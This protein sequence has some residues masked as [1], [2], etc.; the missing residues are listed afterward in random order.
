MAA[1]K[2]TGLGK[3][4][5]AYFG[6]KTANEPAEDKPSAVKAEKGSTAAPR[7]GAGKKAGTEEAAVMLRIALVEP[8]RSQPRKNFDEEALNE[9]ADSIKEYGVLQPI[10]VQ[11]KGDRYEIIAGERRFRAARL[12]GLKEIPAVVRRFPD[13]RIVELSLIEN[14]QRE[15]LNPIEEAAAYQ[16]LSDEFGLKQEEIAER[17][18]KSRTAVA[19]SLR[20]LKLSK[21]V[22]GMVESG[23]LSAGH[24]RAL[25]VITSKT[26]QK[27]LADLIISR[28]LS[29][30]E[31]EQLVKKYQDAAKKAAGKVKDDPEKERE[32]RIRALAYK[33]MEDRLRSGL[34]NKVSILAGK[35]GGKIEIAYSD[36]D[37]LERIIGLIL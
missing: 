23:L 19:N 34:S 3:G 13:D 28:Q 4:I 24:A 14:I 29:V 37:D 1:K 32:D 31:T 27:K 30:R 15:D 10:L 35:K 17:V 11:D 21:E 5:E 22:Q 7:T 20:L 36:D 12:A 9:L 33:D 8:N 2:R 25:V 16:R 6:G 26:E 18:F